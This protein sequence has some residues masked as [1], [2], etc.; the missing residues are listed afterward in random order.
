RSGCA[1]G[2]AGP[3]AARRERRGSDP[4]WPSSCYLRVATRAV[5]IRAPRVTRNVT[6]TSVSAAPQARSCAATNDEFAL[7]KILTDGAVLASWERWGLYSGAAATANKSGAVSPAAR[8]TA[9]SAPDTMP[10]SAAGRTTV[11]MVRLLVVPRA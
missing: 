7:A 5:K 11:R 10:D 4:R 8:A 3:D 9:R 2:P 1:A 6:R